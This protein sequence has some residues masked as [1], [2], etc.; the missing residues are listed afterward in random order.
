LNEKQPIELHKAAAVRGGNP[1][2]HF[3]KDVLGRLARINRIIDRRKG[4]SRA[5]EEGASEN[6]LPIPKR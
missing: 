6:G 2:E 1:R 4:I 3:V 5:S